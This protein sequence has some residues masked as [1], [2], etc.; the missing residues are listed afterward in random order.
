MWA[1]NA[2][3]GVNESH[4]NPLDRDGLIHGEDVDPFVVD[5]EL[6]LDEVRGA[7]KAG[8]A[9]VDAVRRRTNVREQ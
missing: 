9:G 8:S 5:F 4:L 1:E 7:A 2:L 6:E 3:I